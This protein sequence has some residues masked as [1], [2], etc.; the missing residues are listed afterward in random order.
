[1][2]DWTR[3][4]AVLLEAAGDH[5]AERGR[6]AWVRVLDPPDGDPEEGFALAFSDDSEGFLGWVATPDCQAVGLVATGRLRST[7]GGAPPDGDESDD[8]KD[9][10][11]MACL[12]TR[13]G[14]VAWKTELPQDVGAG[15]VP[16]AAPTEG[17]MLDCLR[18][19]FGLPTPP[20]PVSPARLQTIAWLVAVFDRA[21]TAHGRL[22]WFEVSRL[23]PVAQILNAEMGGPRAEL[24]PGLLRVAGSAWTW[25]D[26]RQQAERDGGMEHIVDPSLARWM[27]EGMFARWVL[28]ELPAPDE[29]LATVR[30]HLVPSAARRLAHAVHEAGLPEA[31]DAAT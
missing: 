9:H 31:A 20:P 22:T 6:P 27:D 30:P 19:C 3:L 2:K 16:E 8:V 25:E 28:A 15:V 4:A 17:R 26:F 5:V 21:I 13:E 1:M 29:L 14:E 23:H 11:R 24:L 18:R 7:S 12:L 10:L